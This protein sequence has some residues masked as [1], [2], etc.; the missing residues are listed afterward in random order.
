MKSRA[1]K[2]V[3]LY[4]AALK[5]TGGGQIDVAVPTEMQYRIAACIG[6]VNLSGIPGTE[7][8]DTG[9]MPSDISPPGSPPLAVSSI[10]MGINSNQDVSSPLLTEL[11]PPQPPQF[12]SNVSRELLPASQISAP[13]RH[14]RSPPTSEEPP[15]KRGKKETQTEELLKLQMDMLTEMRRSNEI[16]EKKLEMLEQTIASQNYFLQSLFN[17]FTKNNNI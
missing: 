9:L 8:C 15:R 13:V 4:N 1:K 11:M 12:N 6:D 14:T 10:L 17:F 5:K 16:Q 3:S 7:L 2:A